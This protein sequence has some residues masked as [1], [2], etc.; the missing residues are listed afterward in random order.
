MKKLIAVMA[1]A[2]GIFSATAPAHA[3]DETLAVSIFNSTLSSI[4]PLDLINWRIGDEM[5]YTISLVLGSGTAKKFVA[6]DEGAAL[7]FTQNISILGQNQKVE[8]LIQKADG[9]ILK[10]KVNG[11]EQ[12]VPTPHLEIIDQEVTSITVPAGTFDCV[13]VR[14]KS[15]GKKVE[16]W[17]NPA[18]TVMDGSLKQVADS[19]LIG[20]MTLILTSFKKGT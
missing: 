9:K 18:Q 19:G 11:Q 2:T 10:M 8:A 17:A 6:S 7:W 15:D 20:D 14:A 13:H 5:N 4:S 16:V 3:S 1:L 12:A